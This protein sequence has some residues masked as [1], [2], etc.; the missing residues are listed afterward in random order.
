MVDAFQ[1]GHTRGNAGSD[2]NVVKLAIGQHV[3]VNARVQM[4]VNAQLFNHALVIAQG[5]IKLFLAGHQFGQIELTSDFGRRI[6]KGYVM[7]AFG[8]NSCI[9]PDLQGLRRQRL[10]S[11]GSRSAHISKAFQGRRGD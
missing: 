10:F 6:I 3:G 1:F 11:A 2:Y 7:A 8:G 5:L 4:Q 9:S